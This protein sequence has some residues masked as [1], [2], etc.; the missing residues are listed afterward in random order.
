MVV[1]SACPQPNTPTDEALV[2]D[3]GLLAKG[4][5]YLPIK[6]FPEVIDERIVHGRVVG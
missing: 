3:A 2:V 1:G 4:R 6:Q 5:P